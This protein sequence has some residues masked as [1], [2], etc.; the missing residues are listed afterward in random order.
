M[1][2]YY[3]ERTRTG[4]I[5]GLMRDAEVLASLDCGDH[6]WRLVQVQKPEGKAYI[7]AVDLLESRLIDG[8]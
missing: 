4:L 7:I 1:G 2:W 5:R 3:Q 8:R 6:F